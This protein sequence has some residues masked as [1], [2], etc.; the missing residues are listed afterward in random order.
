[1][2]EA[3][4]NIDRP[5][6]SDEMHAGNMNLKV[7]AISIPALLACTYSTYSIS[8]QPVNI[9]H[10]D[11]WNLLHVYR[12]LTI[13]G[14]KRHLLQCQVGMGPC[15]PILPA[16]PHTPGSGMVTTPPRNGNPPPLG[17]GGCC[18]LPSG[19]PSSSSSSSSGGAMQQ[20]PSM[21]QITGND[22]FGGGPL[23]H[24]HQLQQQQQQGGNSNDFSLDD[25]NFDPAAIIG[26]TDNA[27][28]NVGFLNWVFRNER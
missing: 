11:F 12:I 1:M 28:L 3:V 26:D 14:M 9:V 5:K 13:F 20:L 24:H 25:L 23:H 16:T 22:A 10:C 7:R 4:N 17:A 27:D 2:S 6:T 8:L 18:P 15:T 21:Q 19:P